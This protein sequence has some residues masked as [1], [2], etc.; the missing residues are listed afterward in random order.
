[1][2]LSPIEAA[3]LTAEIFENKSSE[4]GA[5]EGYMKLLRNPNLSYEHAQ[6][7]REICADEQNH[8]LVLG[9]M[10]KFYNGIAATGDGLEPILQAIAD[11]VMFTDS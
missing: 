3:Q 8:D 1:M 4:N 5:L 6:Q 11:G 10:A 2:A 9:A 7:V